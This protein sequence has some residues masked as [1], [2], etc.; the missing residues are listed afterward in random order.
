MSDDV[1]TRAYKAVELFSGGM[2]ITRA[3]AEVG[4]DTG[5]YYKAKASDPQLQA[6]HSRAREDNSE[7]LVWNTLDALD[8]PNVD[9][10]R[11]KAKADHVRF[12]VAK[13]NPRVYG[14]RI[15]V[16]STQTLELGPAL[17]EALSR[18]SLPMRDQQPMTIDVAP[19]ESRAYA[20]SDADKVSEAP[21]V[22]DADPP[23]RKKRQMGPKA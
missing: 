9:L 10:Y 21:G 15:Q 5:T 3:C 20:P 22:Q 17:A 16:D 4:L 6:A 14:E 18:Q 23:K 1:K 7:L 2:S 13:H 8:D 11:A 12:I 19:T